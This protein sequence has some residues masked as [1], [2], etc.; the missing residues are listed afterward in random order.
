[1]SA[2]DKTKSCAAQTH[3]DAAAPTALVRPR[4]AQPV[5]AWRRFR[6]NLATMN[7]KYQN[8]RKGWAVYLATYAVLFV[9]FL[10]PYFYFIESIGPVQIFTVMLDLAAIICLYWHVRRQPL[11]SLGI[12]IVFIGFALVF[13]ARI[14]VILYLLLPN[15]FPWLGSPEQRVSIWGLCGLLFQIP[16]AV[17]LFAYST[18]AQNKRTHAEFALHE[19]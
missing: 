9:I 16:M 1:M 4:P 15:L 3:S 19:E 12:R 14:L 6:E 2:V 13:F 10:Y 11:Q 18:G 17:A 8:Y 7:K 5:F